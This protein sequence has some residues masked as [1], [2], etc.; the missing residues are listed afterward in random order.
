MVELVR[1]AVMRAGD[2]SL[3]LT[4]Y[5]AWESRPCTSRRQYSRNDHDVSNVGE[6]SGGCEHAKAVTASCL[7]CSSVPYL[8]PLPA[9]LSLGELALGA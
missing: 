4:S 3:S 2:L 7:P 8:C 9:W 1:D 5:S 6:Q